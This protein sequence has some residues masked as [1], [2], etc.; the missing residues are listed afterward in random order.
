[1]FWV[2]LNFRKKLTYWL[3]VCLALAILIILLSQLSV[4]VHQA[5]ESY[6]RWMNRDHPHG[7]PVEVYQ[8]LDSIVTDGE[9]PIFKKLKIDRYH[10]QPVE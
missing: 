8:E 7:D 2:I 10:K 4:A 6:R 5:A 9:D 1:M 3:K